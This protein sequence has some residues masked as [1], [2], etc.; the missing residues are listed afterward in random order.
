MGTAMGYFD[1]EPK[2]DP[3]D[4]TE[5]IRGIAR[6][7]TVKYSGHCLTESMPERNFSF[8]DLVAVLLN[9]EVHEPPELDERTRELKYKVVGESIDG[10][11]TVVITVI[12]SHRELSVVTVFPLGRGPCKIQ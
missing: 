12:I 3:A 7:G 9:G 6:F 8:Q 2:D 4:A 10:D 1:C 5:T 11:E